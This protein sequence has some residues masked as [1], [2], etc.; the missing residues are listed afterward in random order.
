MTR[1]FCLLAAG[2]GLSSCLRG[3]KDTCSATALEPVQAVSGP[4]TIAVNQTANFLITYLPQL[5]CNKLESVYE[6]QGSAPN[7]LLIG[8]RV[9]YTDCNCPANTVMAQ[10]TYAFKPTTPGTY[11]LNF[12]ASNANGFIRDTLVVQ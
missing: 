1:F 4:K 7:T 6:A 9:T 10:A 5:T 8:P 12:V 2:F 3:G 11:Y